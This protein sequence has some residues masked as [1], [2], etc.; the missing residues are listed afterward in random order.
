VATCIAASTRQPSVL[1]LRTNTIKGDQSNV[2][3]SI[4]KSACMERRDL[5]NAVCVVRGSEMLS[6]KAQGGWAMLTSASD[7][8]VV[9]GLSTEFCNMAL[10]R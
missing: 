8:A 6:Y 10:P 9:L 7:E 4:G 2:N 1:S 3:N 5:W